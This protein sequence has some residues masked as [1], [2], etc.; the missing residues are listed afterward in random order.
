MPLELTDEQKLLESRKILFELSYK[1]YEEATFG[2]PGRLRQK[3]YLLLQ[4]YT[5]TIG[6][7]PSL[8]SRIVRGFNVAEYS[9]S[10]TVASVVGGLGLILL[11]MAFYFLKDAIHLKE[12]SIFSSSALRKLSKSEAIDPAVL[13]D[14]ASD[15]LYV[16]T[17]QNG[18][19][20]SELSKKIRGSYFSYY[21]SII[22]FLT[23][24]L[25]TL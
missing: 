25:L 7:L 12:Y 19:W 22:L 21:G 5:A 4:L 18:V 3:A 20:A 16:L 9:S 14:V 23:V 17:A 11:L 15:E 1:E 24:Y 13:A 6:V 2:L 8:L 10:A